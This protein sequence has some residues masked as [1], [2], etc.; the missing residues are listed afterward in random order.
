MFDYERDEPC[1]FQNEFQAAYAVSQLTTPRDQVIVPDGM[2]AVVTRSVRYCRYTD[3][4]LP[5]WNEHLHKLCGS[6]RIADYW[7][8]K[9]IDEAGD[10]WEC[11]VVV[12]PEADSVP[13]HLVSYEDDDLPF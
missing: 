1:E 12:L 6:R 5:G 3:A 9:L 11:S 8:K 2:F 10:D 7:A 4:T 13:L